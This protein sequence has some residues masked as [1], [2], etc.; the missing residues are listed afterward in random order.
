[1]KHIKLFEEQTTHSKILFLHGLDSRPYEDR[2]A[3]LK[4][5]GAEV[6]AP[7]INYRQE[8]ETSIAEDIIEKEGITHLIGHSLGGILSFYLSNKH[9]LPALMFNPAFGSIN[10]KYFE[11]IR[12][13]QQYPPF[14]EQYAVVGLKDTVIPP[15]VQLAGLKHA[16][17]FEEPEMPHTIEPKLFKKYVELF[18]EKTNIK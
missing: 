1:M 12:E 9:K 16:H 18:S 15:D 7:H 8:D 17:V 13:L 3:I 4:E 2:L 6:F 10:R 14:E 5:T 11:E